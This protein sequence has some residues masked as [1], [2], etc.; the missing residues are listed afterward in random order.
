MTGTKR[1]LALIGT[2]CGLV[3]GATGASA[4]SR[5][6]GTWSVRMMTESGICDR[7]YSYAIAIEDGNVRYIHAPGD[8]PTTVSGQVGRNGSVD[9]DIRRSIAKVDAFGRLEENSGAG[10]W[11]L[12]MLG[13]TGRWSAQKRTRTVRN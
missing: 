10:S 1:L 3:A 8:S 4:E 12:A 11:R 13:C 2:A 5:H 9:L 7:S 6:D